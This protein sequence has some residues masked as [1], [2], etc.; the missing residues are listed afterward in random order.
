MFIGNSTH[1]LDAKHRVFVPKRFQAQLSHNGENH[2]VAV[3]ARGFDGSLALYTQEGFMEVAKTLRT[4]SFNGM[5]QRKMQRLFFSTAKECQLD[6]SGRLVIPENLREAAGIK[7][8]VV[9]VGVFDR[10]EIWSAEKWNEFNKE[11][12]DKFDSL[13][14][15][16][17][18]SD[19][20]GGADAS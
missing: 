20:A 10:A 15:V 6:K 9:F 5:D 8:D 3:L 4:N 12:D 13:G 2:L 1:T 16:I 17:L 7:K 11:N 18:D 14:P 19:G